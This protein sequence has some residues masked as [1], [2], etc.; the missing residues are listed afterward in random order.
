MF[1][2]ISLYN[3]QEVK[4]TLEKQNLSTLRNQEDA[5]IEELA[6]QRGRQHPKTNLFS[7]HPLSS[8]NYK[9]IGCWGL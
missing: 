2:K 8:N 4:N 6:A 3:A 5:A 9:T 1:R 7:G